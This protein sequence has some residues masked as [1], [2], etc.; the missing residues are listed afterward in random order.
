MHLGARRRPPTALVEYDRWSNLTLI[1]FDQYQS[2]HFFYRDNGPTSGQICLKSLT[3][4]Q[5]Y[6]KSGQI[7]LTGSGQ[8]PL[9]SGQIHLTSGQIISLV[10]K[11]V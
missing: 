3:S 7:R 4:G 8:I 6:L 2:L 11:S 10:V 5:N 1:K 9:N